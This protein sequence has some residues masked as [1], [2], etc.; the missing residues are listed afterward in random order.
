MRKKDKKQF[1]VC[2]VVGRVAL[3]YLFVC[4]CKL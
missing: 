2:R 1:A 4:M 3:K